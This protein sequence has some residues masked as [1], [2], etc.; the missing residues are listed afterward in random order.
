[1]SISRVKNWIAAETLSASDLNAEFNNFVNYLN[2]TA[3]AAFISPA[4]T[5]TVTGGANYVAGLVGIGDGAVGAPG[6]Y[7][8][9]DTDNGA[10]RIGANNWA[11]SAAGAKALELSSGAVTA[12]SAL[13]VGMAPTN[14]VDILKT[15]DGPGSVSIKN[16]SNGT[17]AYSEL[18]AV[19][20][21][22][23]TLTARMYGASYTTSGIQR[24]DGGL[25]ASNGAGGLTIGTTFAAPIY[26]IINSAEVFR[27]N[28]AGELNLGFGATDNG[29]YL[30]QVNSQIFATNATVATSDA[31]LK[32]ELPPLAPDVLDKIAAIPTRMYD[33][34]DRPQDGS[35]AGYFAQDWEAIFGL[36]TGIVKRP[37]SGKLQLDEGAAHSLKIAAMERRINQL[38]AR[39]VAANIA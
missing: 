12:W 2:G 34:L 36:E 4:I 7:F 19:N 33:R 6:L 22:T 32:S 37:P 8:T 15:V 9:S 30:L 35:R 5:G 13:G 31:T 21:N 38:E 24:Q 16:A 20:L 23:N 25:L 26:G 14:V 3:T 28:T 27:V 39:V 10:Y 11:L 29:A 1:M 17:A 18:M